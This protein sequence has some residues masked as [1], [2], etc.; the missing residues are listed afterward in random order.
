[1]K[2]LEIPNNT[3]FVCL[4]IFNLALTHRTHCSGLK[5]RFIGLERE[6]DQILPW[7]TWR[8]LLSSLKRL[9]CSSA[10]KSP[11][12]GDSLK[13]FRATRLGAKKPKWEPLREPHTDNELPGQAGSRSQLFQI[14]FS[15]TFKQTSRVNQFALTGHLPIG[16]QSF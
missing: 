16:W 4:F 6:K 7:V 2:H 14:Q 9:S 12:L 8:A 11:A 10:S 3:V 13:S 15:F 1:M 5:G